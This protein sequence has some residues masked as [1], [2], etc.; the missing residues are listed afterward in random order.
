MATEMAEWLR[1]LVALAEDL[2][3]LPSTRIRQLIA[4]CNSSSRKSGTLLQTP[5]TL[6]GTKPED[7]CHPST[8]TPHILQRDGLR[9][10]VDVHFTSRGHVV[11]KN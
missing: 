1:V 3:S 11:S 10:I 7:R 9:F 6:A 8:H 4:S 5:L 2:G